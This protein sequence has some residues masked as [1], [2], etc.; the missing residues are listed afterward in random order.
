MAEVR[1]HKKWLS[2]PTKGTNPMEVLVTDVWI[3]AESARKPNG[4]PAASRHLTKALRE[5]LLGE[6]PARTQH[7][8]GIP[9][10]QVM[11]GPWGVAQPL[12][13]GNR[14]AGRA[15]RRASGRRDRDGALSGRTAPGAD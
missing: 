5:A 1:G 7:E 4:D 9:A 13:S 8:W 6:K 3:E 14:A 15:L 12:N 11:A 2:Q 10:G